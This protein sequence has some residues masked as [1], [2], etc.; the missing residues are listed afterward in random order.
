MLAPASLWEFGMYGAPPGQKSKA[1]TR[2]SSSRG[3]GC[4][5]LLTL[6]ALWLEGCPQQGQSSA[7]GACPPRDLPSLPALARCCCQSQPRW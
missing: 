6:Q 5:S 4:F 7:A 2:G 1:A 3:L